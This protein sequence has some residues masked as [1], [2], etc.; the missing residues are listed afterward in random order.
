MGPDYIGLRVLARSG[1]DAQFLRGIVDQ[2][3]ATL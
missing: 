2:V 3:I 1:R